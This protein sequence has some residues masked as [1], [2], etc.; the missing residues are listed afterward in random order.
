MKRTSQKGKKKQK[1]KVMITDKKKVSLVAQVI[2]K[3]AI[4][5]Q[6]QRASQITN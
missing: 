2:T 1:C 5:G 6:N 4:R 3:K